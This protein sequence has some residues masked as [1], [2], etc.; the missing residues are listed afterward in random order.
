MFFTTI[1]YGVFVDENSE[2]ESGGMNNRLDY[3]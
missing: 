3:L 2:R 1:Q